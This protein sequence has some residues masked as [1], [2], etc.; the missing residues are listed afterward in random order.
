MLSIRTS[1]IGLWK[2]TVGTGTDGLRHCS[3]PHFAP[4]C[5]ARAPGRA[6]DPGCPLRYV[7]AR[8]HYEYLLDT[9]Y[10][11]PLCVHDYVRVQALDDEDE[12]LI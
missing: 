10:S 7:W 2:G 6:K 12:T 8:G 1:G 3:R 9:M 5:A 4:L 11:S